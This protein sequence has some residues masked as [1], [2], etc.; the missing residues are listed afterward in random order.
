M[1]V[2]KTAMR[3]IRTRKSVLI[4][5]LMPIVMTMLYMSSSPK[6]SASFSQKPVSFAVQNLDQE[7]PLSQALIDVMSHN[8][9]LVEY[10][11][12]PQELRNKLFYMKINYTL[13]IPENFFDDYA[14]YVAGGANSGLTAPQLI[15][16][17]SASSEARQIN[18]IVDRFL[19]VSAA[20]LAGNP[21]QDKAGLASQLVTDLTNETEIHV[22]ESVQGWSIGPSDF[23][24]RFSSYGMTAS[25]VFI[26]GFLFLAFRDK[27]VLSRQIASPTSYSQLNFGIS[28]AQ[29][30]C[31]LAIVLLYWLAAIQY[32]PDTI[33]TTIGFLAMANLL[34]FSLVI[35][36]LS[37]LV[38]T[39][40]KSENAVMVVGNVVPLTLSF[41]GG[42]FIPSQYLSKTVQQIANFLPT[43]WYTNSLDEFAKLSQVDFEGIKPILNNFLVLAAFG[44]TFTIV[45]F[46]LNHFLNRS[47][48]EKL[49][50]AK[51]Y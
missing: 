25:I 10:P 36:S 31:T 21:N 20:K 32:L 42:A 7:N 9:D 1:Q 3:I 24:F 16:V 35:F 49:A 51:K 33:F 15:R 23:F 17:E 8:N 34:L 43:Y 47:T 13:T 46:G 30:I 38:A 5:I 41:F 45:S 29:L 11:S 18:Q 37:I 12:D 27:K 50:V 39:T 48:G 28:M 22:I 2:F 4:Y 19:T 14:A 40:L 44:L 26:S 6:P